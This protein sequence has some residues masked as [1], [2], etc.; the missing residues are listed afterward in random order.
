MSKLKNRAPELSKIS[1]EQ[2]F[3]VPPKYFDDF[4]ARL[5]SRME[6]E[7]GVPP[8]PGNRLVRLLKPALAMA[9][10]FALIF[11]LGYWPLKSF[12]PDFLADKN[13]T[14]DTSLE[15]ETFI[16]LVDAIDEQ[17]FFALLM[18]FPVEQNSVESGL[19]D[20]ELMNYLSTQVSDYEIYLQTTN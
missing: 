9:A 7:A 17:S 4:Y 1:K 18:D 6:A 10:S 12:L 13:A 15:D 3:V 8:L 20:E 11:L 14:T 5:H 19:N 2:P 16:S